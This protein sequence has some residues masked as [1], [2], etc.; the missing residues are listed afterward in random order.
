[1]SSSYLMLLN[2]ANK[3]K[4]SQLP[5]LDDIDKSL[6]YAT[7]YCANTREKLFECN[8]SLPYV[9]NGGCGFNYRYCSAC[10]TKWNILNAEKFNALA[11]N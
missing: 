7:Y 5:I 11:K 10:Y 4:Q 9:K 1:M 3:N 2:L 8:T 6:D